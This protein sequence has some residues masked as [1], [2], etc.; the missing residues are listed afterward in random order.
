M[1]DYQEILDDLEKQV[2]KTENEFEEVK[3][4]G[5]SSEKQEKAEELIQEIRGQIEFLEEQMDKLQ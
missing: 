2:E 4:S 5:Q 1:N 3:D